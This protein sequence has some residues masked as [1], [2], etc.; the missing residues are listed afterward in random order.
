[1]A[2]G[3]KEIRG[4][5]VPPE[6][7][8]EFDSLRTV[9]DTKSALD[10]V[11]S[12]GKWLFSSA[13]IVGSLGAGLSNAAFSKLRGLGAWSF[14]LAV[15]ALGVCLVAASRSVAPQ[16]VE[17]RLLDLESLRSA[18]N[19]Q[20][21]KR[22]TLLTIAASFFALALALAGLSP[23]IS[24]ATTPKSGPN[25]HYTLDDKGTLD[26]GLEGTGL[27]PGTIVEL[28]IEASNAKGPLPVSVA[29]VDESGQI[30]LSLKI[31]I[32]NIVSGS[33]DLVGCE[34]RSGDVSCAITHRV[35][36]LHR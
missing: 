21:K 28:R 1:M 25:I 6:V 24:L 18:V 15:V 8:A 16:W 23:L 10:R 7:K 36:V 11:D 34:R 9:F 20:F 26:G 17:V 12:Y 30:K 5:I 29:T 19:S 31:S 4:E 22:Q 14:A 33:I 32:A 13:A 35:P 3:D 2:E 27:K